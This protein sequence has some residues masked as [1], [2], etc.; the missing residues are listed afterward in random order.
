MAPAAPP[1]PVATDPLRNLRQPSSAGELLPSLDDLDAAIGAPGIQDPLA[2]GQ[3]G[4]GTV[5]VGVPWG[6]PCAG[7]GIRFLAYLLDMLWIVGVQT[8]AMIFS[9]SDPIFTGAASLLTT[10]VIFLGW[11][12]W[13]TTPGKRV[14]GLYLHGEDGQTGIGFLRAFIRMVG[15]LLS[16]LPLGAGFL[17][18]LFTKDHRGLHDRIARTW[19]Y[20]HSS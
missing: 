5:P 19:V 14:V 1:P 4:T 13:G 16:S 2:A 17:M 15:Y 20:R 3:K 9:S 10:L 7:F 11:S 8:A 6:E 18:I 12:I